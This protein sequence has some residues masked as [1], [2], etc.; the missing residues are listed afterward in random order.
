MIIAER[1]VVGRMQQRPGPNRT[2]PGGW[3]QSLADDRGEGHHGHQPH[4]DREANMQPMTVGRVPALAGLS[5]KAVRLYGTGGCSPVRSAPNRG[6]GCSPPRPRRAAL[7]AGQGPRPDP[8]R[9]QGRAAAAAGRGT[10]LR[11]R[12]RPAREH[13]PGI[14]RKLADPRGWGRAQRTA[15]SAADTALREGRDAVV[16]RIMEQAPT[17]TETLPGGH[18]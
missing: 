6:T 4:P 3:L 14:D 9:D 13:L 15:R 8:V 18:I 11:T 2:G 1:K 7:P 16:C 17:D 12:H 5:P 10:D